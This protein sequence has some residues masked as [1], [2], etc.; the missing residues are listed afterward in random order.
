VATAGLNK[1]INFPF[2]GNGFFADKPNRFPN[3]ITASAS[4]SL[5]RPVLSGG[6]FMTSEFSL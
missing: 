1:E 2:F 3:S 6:T 4:Y 5:I